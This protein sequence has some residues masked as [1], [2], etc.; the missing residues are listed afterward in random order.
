[1]TRVQVQARGWAALAAT[2]LALLVPPAALASGANP[3]SVA[4]VAM[5]LGL[6]SGVLLAR[7]VLV[8]AEEEKGEE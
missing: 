5:G 6:L 4:G 8:P 7:W 1:M 3:G 2:V